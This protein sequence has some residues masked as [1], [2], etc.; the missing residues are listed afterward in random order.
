[1]R[2][3]QWLPRKKGMCSEACAVVAV[4]WLPPRVA[5]T[6]VHRD[7]VEAES[8]LQYYQRSIF[9]SYDDGLSSSL[10]K[11]F[12]DN[13]FFCAA[14][15]LASYNDPS[16]IDQI[17]SLYL[18]DNLANEVRLWRNSLTAH[19]NQE[20]L[21]EFLLSAQIYPSDRNVIQIVITLPATTVRAERSFACMRRVKTC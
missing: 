16:N 10:R 20:S 19:V 15:C 18:L 13:P 1:M 3:V 4:Q 12:N 8:A 9:L 17:E 7:N 2:H 14:F 6:Q 5:G 21:S 11:R